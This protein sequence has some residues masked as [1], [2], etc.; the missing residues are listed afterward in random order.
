MGGADKFNSYGD[1]RF[2][3]MHHLS[4]VKSHHVFDTCIPE[5]LKMNVELELFSFLKICLKFKYCQNSEI[6]I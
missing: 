3:E 6:E 2:S 5:Y 1:K 4:A